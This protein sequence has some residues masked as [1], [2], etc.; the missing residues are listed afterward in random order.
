M[1]KEYNSRLN[2]FFPKFCCKI[3]KINSKSEI[4][5]NFKTLKPSVWNKKPQI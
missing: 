4:L 5:P 3:A 1:M 2:I